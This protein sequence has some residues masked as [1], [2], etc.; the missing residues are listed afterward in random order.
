MMP[1]GSRWRTVGAF[2]VAGNIG[3]YRVPKAP[4]KGSVRVTI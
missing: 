4:F 1:N 3:T 2:I